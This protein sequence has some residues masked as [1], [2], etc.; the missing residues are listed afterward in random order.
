MFHKGKGKAL[1]CTGT[2]A[3]YRPG[4]AHKGSRDITLLFIDYGTGRG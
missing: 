2:E 3:L 1:P 4:V